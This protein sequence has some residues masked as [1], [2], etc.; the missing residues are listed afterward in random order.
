MY[1]LLLRKIKEINVDDAL[2]LLEFNTYL[3]QR[4]IRIPHL[5]MLCNEIKNGSFLTGDIAVVKMREVGNECTFLVNGQHQ[6][7]AIIKTGI[8]ITVVYQEYEC[9][10]DEDLSDLY[11]RFDNHASRTLGDIVRPEA[12][13]LGIQWK[14]SVI[15]LVVTAATFFDGM[16]KKS[17]PKVEKIKELANYIR[18]GE[19]VDSIILDSKKQRFMMNS[20]VCRTMIDTWQ[21][22]RIKAKVFWMEVRDGIGLSANSPSLVLRNY[23]LSTSRNRGSSQQ[24][25]RELY[26]KCIHG[27]N[28]YVTDKTTVLAY[29]RDSPIPKIRSSKDDC[30]L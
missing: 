25:K 6:L 5:S 7:K 23:L 9:K 13:A 3:G 15:N 1:K 12:V 8:S 22:D 14:K 24:Q 26:V 29:F 28:A 21:K 20:C 10:T 27:W 18:E 30:L 2:E 17:R 11:R 4:D 19:F 16:S